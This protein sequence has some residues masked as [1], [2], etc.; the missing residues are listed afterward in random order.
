M[1][2]MFNCH[3]CGKN[4]KTKFGLMQH[5]KEHQQQFKHVCDVCAK[6]F[7][8]PSTFAIHMNKHKNEKP[9][10]CSKCNKSYD[11]KS[12]LGRHQETCGIQATPFACHI[13]QKTFRAKR[14]L[15][16]HMACHSDSS[17]QCPHCG[18]SYN[19]RASLS[20]H[21]SKKHKSV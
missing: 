3:E 15:N 5:I 18:C 11:S 13:C 9:Y 14:Y 8:Y 21:I 10:S 16:D 17:F 2:D 4:Y 19:L 20:S 1:G 12:V 6:G 7:N